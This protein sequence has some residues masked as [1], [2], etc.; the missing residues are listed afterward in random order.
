[1]RQVSSISSL[2]IPAIA[3]EVIGAVTNSSGP[4]ATQQLT[5]AVIILVIFFA[6]GAFFSFTRATL[7]TIAGERIVARL[8]KQ[9][10]DAIM[11]QD[12]AF[13]DKN[14][15]G[16]LI[17]RL[18]SDS[19]VIQSSLSVNISMGLRFSATVIGGIIILFVVSWRLTLVML[20]ILPVVIGAAMV[21]GK[22]IKALSKQVQDAL[23]S[24][25]EVSEGAAQV[26]VGF[27][28]VCVRVRESECECE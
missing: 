27:A 13:F 1:M 10:F 15:T 6:V 16:E 2:A 28:C 19:A 11:R 18:S 26:S 20:S 17:N 22:V 9:V 14:K 23:A 12:I 3:G 25:N 8:R 24:A 4:E 21:Y 7:Y 5:R